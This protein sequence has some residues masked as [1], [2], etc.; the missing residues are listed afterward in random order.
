MHYFTFS[1]RH[2][3]KSRPGPVYTHDE[4]FTPQ[5]YEAVNFLNPDRVSFLSAKN[6]KIG[7][8]VMWEPSQN[9]DKPFRRAQTDLA[10]LLYR[11]HQ[12]VAC[13]F[14]P[15]GAKLAPQGNCD[16]SGRLIVDYTA[17]S[18]DMDR[19]LRSIQI[20]FEYLYRCHGSTE[21][22]LKWAH[23]VFHFSNMRAVTGSSKPVHFMLRGE[24]G[25]ENH[26]RI[27]SMI[28]HLVTLAE[29]RRVSQSVLPGVLHPP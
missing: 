3:A 17:D 21:P 18:L 1:Q 7:R 13:L 26:R 27:H 16:A 11:N 5:V 9:P 4:L 24:T 29:S 28:Q 23:Y 22:F 12:R 19:I 10:S 8:L 15:W 14:I 25:I 2:I 6:N 20:A